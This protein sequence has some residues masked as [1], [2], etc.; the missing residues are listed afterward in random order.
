MEQKDLHTNVAAPKTRSK[1]KQE[2]IATSPKAIAAAK[3]RCYQAQR[4]A[5]LVTKPI[6]SDDDLTEIFTIPKSSLL[7]LKRSLKLPQFKIGKRNFIAREALLA[8]IA[9]RG[10]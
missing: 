3:I 9:E 10:K 7:A 4:V 5:S 6:F 1:N 2:K 8:W